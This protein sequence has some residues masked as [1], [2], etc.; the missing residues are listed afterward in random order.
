[1][2]DAMI[3]PT[4]AP[5]GPTPGGAD[6]S[7]IGA[8]RD[9]ANEFEAIFLAQ[10]LDTMTQGLGADGLLGGGEGE[11]FR[12]MLNDE[13]AKL[14]SRSGGIRVADAVLQE[15]LKMQEVG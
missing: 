4:L 6:H 13:V 5:A 8:L 11:V 10:V 2:S 15:M 12:D 1:M 3:S 7:R 9:A 14:I